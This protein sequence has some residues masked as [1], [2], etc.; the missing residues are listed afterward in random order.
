MHR[1]RVKYYTRKAGIAV[2]AAM[3][4]LGTVHLP[5]AQLEVKAAAENGDPGSADALAKNQ[6]TE[7]FEPLAVEVTAEEGWEELPFDNSNLQYEGQWKQS[8]TSAYSVD[9][10]G[11]VSLTFYGTGIR[12]Y[13]QRDVNFAI[14]NVEIDG[15][16]VAQVDTFGQGADAHTGYVLYESTELEADKVH[17]IKISHAAAHNPGGHLLGRRICL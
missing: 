3:L 2:L 10:S 14:A 16:P 7:V 13:G 9:E 6:E 12:W 5:G 1:K 8:A 15:M 11:S 4:L 17:T